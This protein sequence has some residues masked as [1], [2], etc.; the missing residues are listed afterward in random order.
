M[1]LL[2]LFYFHFS[3][4]TIYSVDLRRKFEIFQNNIHEFGQDYRYIFSFRKNKSKLWIV[5]TISLQ[6]RI[7]LCISIFIFLYR[8]YYHRTCPSVT[9]WVSY[10]KQELTSVYPRVFGG[11]LVAHDVYYNDGHI[12]YSLFHYLI[13]IQK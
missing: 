12:L 6:L 9:R 3:V 5:E 7:F 1:N 11:L 13:L 2:R 8:Q 10:K 4:W